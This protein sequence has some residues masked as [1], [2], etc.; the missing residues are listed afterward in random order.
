MR[1]SLRHTELD[2]I[3]SGMSTVKHDRVGVARAGMLCVNVTCFQL[4]NV[5]NKTDF[6]FTLYTKTLNIFLNLFYF[7]GQG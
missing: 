1:F 2:E 4:E 7:N 3:K 5:L 6:N